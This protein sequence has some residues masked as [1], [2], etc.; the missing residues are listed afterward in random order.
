[1][2]LLRRCIRD[3]HLV[4]MGFAA[5]RDAEWNDA[6]ACLRFACLDRGAG[7]KRGVNG[8]CGRQKQRKRGAARQKPGE[9]QAG[10]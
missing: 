9:R 8:K 7:Q 6:Q 2:R 3:F 1:M 5:R 10:G 4:M